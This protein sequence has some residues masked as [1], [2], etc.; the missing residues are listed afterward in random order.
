MSKPNAALEL[1]KKG[2]EELRTQLELADRAY[3]PNIT[4]SKGYGYIALYALECM[5]EN[6]ENRPEEEPEGE[7]VWKT[8]IEPNAQNRK[9]CSVCDIECPSKDNYY[10]HPKFCHNCGTKMKGEC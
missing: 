7:W 6:I 4:I 2:A 1:Y 9:Y 5:I 3:L 10:L 8:K